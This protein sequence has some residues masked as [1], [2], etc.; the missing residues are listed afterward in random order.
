MVV[1]SQQQQSQGQN[2]EEVYAKQ[3]EQLEQMGF[4]NKAVNLQVLQ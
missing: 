2:L 4:T 3:L 1:M